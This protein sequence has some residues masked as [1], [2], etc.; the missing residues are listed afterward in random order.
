MFI[1]YYIFTLVNF[2]GKRG[3]ISM[4][5]P[6]YIVVIISCL[7]LNS[8]NKSNEYR[9]IPTLIPSTTYEY[10]TSFVMRDSIFNAKSYIGTVIPYTKELSFNYNG[11]ISKVHVSL[12]DKVNKGQLLLTMYDPS[13][14]NQM[15]ELKK[16]IKNSKQL[17][18]Y[19]NKQLSYDIDILEIEIDQLSKQYNQSKINEEKRNLHSQI[20]LN[21]INLENL[22]VQLEHNKK[23]QT[24]DAEVLDLQLQELKKQSK[25]FQLKAPFEGYVVY[26][27]NVSPDSI[28]NPE[29]VMIAIADTTQP[30]L[31]CDLIQKEDL[32]YCDYYYAKIHNKDY[33]ISLMTN[34]AKQYNTPT[35]LFAFEQSDEQL[36][37]GDHASIYIMF[38][39]VENTLVIPLDSLFKE[40]KTYF[41]YRIENDRLIRQN[42]TV[43]VK[44]DSMV[45]I[46]DG[47]KEGDELYVIN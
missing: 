25:H 41:V 9:D 6:F 17:N 32:N 33:N 8:C 37:I 36:Q 26:L 7:I 43:G 40:D 5:K 2:Y 47:L 46:T 4:K 12:G 31:R 19:N 14:I 15:K 20:E 39:Y 24:I 45:E 10:S 22:H 23:L 1:N 29:T 18:N 11:R 16:Q 34:E 30:L 21:K 3:E 44:S 13:H 28:V 42:V 27:A 38:E 35:L